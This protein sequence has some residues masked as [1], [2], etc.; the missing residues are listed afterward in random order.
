MGQR[1]TKSNKMECNDVPIAN[2][3]PDVGTTMAQQR[4]D[5]VLHAI[6]TAKHMINQ[7]HFRD[8]KHKKA[9]CQQLSTANMSYHPLSYQKNAFRYCFT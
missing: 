7:R 6:V 9:C 1:G 2:T 8:G 5:K 4:D 3:A